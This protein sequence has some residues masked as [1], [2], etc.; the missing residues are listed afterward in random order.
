M[1]YKCEICSYI[2]DSSEGDPENGIKAGT[3]LKDLP[4]EWVCPICGIDKDEFYP[5][6]DEKRAT[7]G[8]SPMALMILALTHGLWTI[9]GRGSY[10]VTREIG[11]AFINELKAAGT[12]LNDNESALKSIEE[13]FI[14]HKFAKDMEYKIKENEVELEIKNCRFFGLC[15]QLENQG[16][17]ITTCP[18]TNT[19]AMALEETDGYRY[20]ISKEQKGYGHYINLK[21]VSKI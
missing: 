1:K 12:E 3:G 18:Y 6:E 16:V 7:D 8:E 4:L 19:V 14:S 9:S 11:R 5:L 17:L 20:R 21:K 2:Y 13:Y 10:S 15:K